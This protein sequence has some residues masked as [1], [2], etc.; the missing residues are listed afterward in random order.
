MAVKL[1]RKTNDGEYEAALF[2]PHIIQQQIKHGGWKL[3]P[4]ECFNGKRKVQKIS[5]KSEAVSN[6]KKVSEKNSEEE[7]RQLAKS[8][9]IRNWHNKKIENL[10]KE[11][12]V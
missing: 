5:S 4:E 6:S 11:L 1:Y 8:K 2:D 9:K 12:E 10:K 7:I 3:S